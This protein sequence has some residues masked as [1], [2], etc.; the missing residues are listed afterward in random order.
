M[1]ILLHCND[2]QVRGSEDEWLEKQIESENS[3]TEL[4]QQIREL[5]VMMSALYFSVFMIIIVIFDGC[6]GI[7]QKSAD[8]L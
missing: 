7:G 5:K 2:W 6:E 3:I 1:P 4:E 8:L